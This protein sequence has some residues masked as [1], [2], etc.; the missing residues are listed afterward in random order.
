[1]SA[2]QRRPRAYADRKMEE[3]ELLMTE[4]ILNDMESLT[5]TEPIKKITF[6]VYIDHKTMRWHCG[7]CKC[8]MRFVAAREEQWMGYHICLLCNKKF[9]SL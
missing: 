2:A 8:Q 4:N 1:M 3:T 7:D 6:T 5:V 9:F